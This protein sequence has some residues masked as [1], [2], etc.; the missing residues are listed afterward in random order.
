MNLLS[1]HLTDPS[2]SYIYRPDLSFSHLADKSLEL[3]CPVQ[4][5]WY[6]KEFKLKFKLSKI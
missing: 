3:L 4:K 6:I 1:Q 2:Q 5:P